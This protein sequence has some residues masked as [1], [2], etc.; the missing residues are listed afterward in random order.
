MDANEELKRVKCSASGV[1]YQGIAATG[2]R[3]PDA[4][5]LTLIAVDIEALI[6]LWNEIMGVELDQRA[7]YPVALFSQ[8]DITE[9]E[10]S[11]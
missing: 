10:V 6:L 11:I 7:V 8:R 5:T 9:I 2:K 3:S 4:P 1:C